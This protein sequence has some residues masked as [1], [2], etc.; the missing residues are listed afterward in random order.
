MANPGEEITGNYLKWVLG[1]D[2]VEY[3][4]TT[5]NPKGEIDVIGYDIDNNVVYICEVATHLETGL[6]YTK[7]NQPDNVDRLFKKFEKDMQYGINYWPDYS[8]IYMLWA[9]IVKSSKPG[10]KHNQMADLEKLKNKLKKKFGDYGEIELIINERYLGCIQE[11]KK[12]AIKNTEA[13][14]NPIMR[15]LQI[16]E[17]TKNH[18]S[19]LNKNK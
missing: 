19:K 15:F 2:F 9:P 17:K 3:N 13:M 7:N 18:V 12:I 1:C 5:K 16:H 10:S 8:V 11:L 14:P 4:L 6:Q